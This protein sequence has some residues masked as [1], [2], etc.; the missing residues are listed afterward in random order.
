MN[1][2]EIVSNNTKNGLQRCLCNTIDGRKC[3]N[4][5]KLLN[6]GMC[7]IHNKSFIHEKF[8]PLI[9]EYINLIL[10]QRKWNNDKN[11]LNRYGQ[12]NNHEIL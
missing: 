4:K 3:K 8:Y 10:L 11:F 5:A 7:H 12:K 2:C 6:Y 9:T 1:L